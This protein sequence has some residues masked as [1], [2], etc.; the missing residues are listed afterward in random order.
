MGAGIYSLPIECPLWHLFA[1][2]ASAQG[3]KRHAMRHRDT[4]NALT[5]SGAA[6][7]PA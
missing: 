1:I 5:R 7:F 4:D 6:P 3:I 2:I